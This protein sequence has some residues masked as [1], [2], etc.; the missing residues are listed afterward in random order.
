MNVSRRSSTPPPAML[1]AAK[2]DELPLTAASATELQQANGLR[3][4]HVRERHVEAHSKQCRPH[5]RVQH[6]VESTSASRKDSP[7]PDRGGTEVVQPVSEWPCRA[8]QAGLHESPAPAAQLFFEE[9]PGGR[10][11]G[12]SAPVDGQWRLRIIDARE[13]V[14]DCF[15]RGTRRLQANRRR[16]TRAQSLQTG[17]TCRCER[18][19]QRR[20]RS[21]GLAH[22]L[23]YSHRCERSSVL[24]SVCRRRSGR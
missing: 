8:A 20:L 15:T 13:R 17:T 18:Q 21:R 11:R 14:T 10:G 9:E 22:A 2:R 1:K 19:D 23:D 12:Q 7:F 24:G 5:E 3:R 4:G 6:M 16:N